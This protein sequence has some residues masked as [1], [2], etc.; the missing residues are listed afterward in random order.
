MI[1]L[2]PHNDDET[3][4]GAYTLIR[5]KPLVLIITDGWIQFL[6]GDPITAIQ[7]R[8]ETERAMAILKCPV[9]FLGIKDTE[10]TANNLRESLEPYRVYDKIYIPAVQGGNSQHDLVGLVAGELFRVF[11]RYTTYTKTELWPKGT[12]EIIPTQEEKDLK[13]KALDCYQSQI[14]LGA[15]RPHFDAVSG[16]SEWLI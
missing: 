10:L 3:L 9:E 6:R 1:F 16:K 12:E 13:N 2:S 14:R 4:F 11:R 7:R 5:E 15:T 8:K